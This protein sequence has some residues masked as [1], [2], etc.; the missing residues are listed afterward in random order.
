MAAENNTCRLRVEQVSPPWAI[1]ENSGA[2]FGTTIGLSGDVG[3]ELMRLAVVG[4]W[5]NDPDSPDDVLALAGAEFRLP[6]YASETSDAYR[7]RILDAWSRY[8]N[9]GTPA[10]INAEI[11]A[12][13]LSGTVTFQPDH[14]GP[15]PEL[16]V[17]Y[18]SQFWITI[19]TADVTDAGIAEMRAIVAKW[20]SVYWIFRGFIL[21]GFTAPTV[22]IG[23]DA[24]GEHSVGG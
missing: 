2:Y 13:G 14:P 23:E 10:R 4:A 15:P 22:S 21:T 6:R 8:D 24:V 11:A 20:K 17:P 12:A 5:L 7:A 9:A 18:W 16:A 3:F 1:G 19:T